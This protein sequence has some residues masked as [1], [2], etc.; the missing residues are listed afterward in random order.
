MRQQ[1][2]SNLTA[3]VWCGVVAEAA[4][5]GRST[6]AFLRWGHLFFLAINFL[7]T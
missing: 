2:R 7:E 4:D 5:E 3:D 1:A 6:E